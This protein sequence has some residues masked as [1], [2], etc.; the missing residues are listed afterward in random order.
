MFVSKLVDE[1]NLRFKFFAFLT[2]RGH[3][4][5]KRMHLGGLFRGDW[6]TTTSYTSAIRVM[7]DGINIPRIRMRSL[8][9]SA[10]NLHRVVSYIR[11]VQRAND[12]HSRISANG[13]TI[14]PILSG[15]R[16]NPNG[17]AGDT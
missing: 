14:P 11:N 3:N 10:E 13:S 12:L 5:K 6:I 1:N 16:N 9:V 2:N 4:K 7:E 17:I 15:D 8:N